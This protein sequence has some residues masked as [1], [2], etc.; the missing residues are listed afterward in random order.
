M[1]G[2]F[3]AV[4]IVFLMVSGPHAGK[5][6]YKHGSK[7]LMVGSVLM[8]GITMFL[9][10]QFSPTTSELLIILTLAIE[11]VAVGLFM[12]PNMKLIASS[13]NKEK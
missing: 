9:F 11:G 10:S 13:G 5:L 7:W 6:S 3:L 12:P 1:A 4:P 2:I 8:A